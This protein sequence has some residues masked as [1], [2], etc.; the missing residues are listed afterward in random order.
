[1]NAEPNVYKN[2]NDKKGDVYGESREENSPRK[3]LFSLLG[4]W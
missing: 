4:R 2:A 1:M 3:V